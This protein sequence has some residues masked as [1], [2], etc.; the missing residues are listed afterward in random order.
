MGTHEGGYAGL[1][2]PHAWQSELVSEPSEHYGC[3]QDDHREDEPQQA[4]LCR[5]P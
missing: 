3:D 5:P 1:S 4:R 2:V